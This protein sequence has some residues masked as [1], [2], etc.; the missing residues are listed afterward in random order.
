[1]ALPERL[2]GRLRLP[3]IAAPMFLVSGP[4]LAL[5]A[6]KAGIVG[7]LPALN[8]RTTE[9]FS[10]WMD[11]VH[12]ALS[13]SS[14]SG[15][16][17]VNVPTPKFGGKRYEADMA[18]V[19]RYRVPIVIT[20]IGDPTEVVQAVHGWGGM[21]L[22]DATTVAHAQKA[23]QA[24]VD[25]L[26]L[27]CAGAGGHAGVLNPFAFVP[28][29]RKFFDGIICL[30]GALA[31]GDAIRAAQVLGADLVYMGSR[32]IA[33]QES[34]AADEYKSL[35]VSEGSADILYTPAVAGLAGNFMRSSMRRV[36]LDP[37]NLPAPLA[38]HR[39]NLPEGIKAWKNI[40]SAGQGIGLIDDLPTVAE[41]V[42]RLE[43][44]YRAAS[45][46]ALAS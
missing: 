2:Q 41:L 31:T 44:Q 29:V 26:N 28:Q 40:W 13:T 20:A 19:E 1:M 8:A 22:H 21:V 11:E 4:E 36:G 15:L 35:L 38:P 5:A 39:P 30:A 43:S 23:V 42:D 9:E 17:A 27:I 46:R 12:G 7:G 33:T 25:G 18:V 45:S 37:D 34:R 16:L 32:F 24:G 3:L 6:C 10:Q 14:A